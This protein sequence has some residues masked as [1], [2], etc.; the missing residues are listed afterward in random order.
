[1]FITLFKFFSS[2]IGKYIGMALLVGYLI[3][4]VWG[5]LKLRDSGVRREALMEFNRKQMELVLQEQQEQKKRWENFEQNVLPKLFESIT[6]EIQ[7]TQKKVDSVEGY[8]SSEEANK[9]DRP[10]SEIIK[11]VL[12]RLGAPR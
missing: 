4:M 8:L 6:K 3:A 7:D 11:E 9:E 2:P 12:R 5:A 1:M 10:A